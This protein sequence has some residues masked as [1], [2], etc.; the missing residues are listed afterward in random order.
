MPGVK[1]V[2]ETQASPFSLQ[3]LHDR[4]LWG[5]QRDHFSGMW[6]LDV[7]ISFLNL[8]TS[9]C[10]CV[11]LFCLAMLIF[12]H[13]HRCTFCLAACCYI[14]RSSSQNC[15]VCWYIVFSDEDEDTVGGLEK[16]DKFSETS[17]SSMAIVWGSLTRHLKDKH[18]IPMVIHKYFWCHFYGL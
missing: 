15:F 2:G 11:L 12:T 14:A 3:H 5:G 13:I 17:E 6:Q 4:A 8:S 16:K 7:L 18:L 10:P 9:F 1:Q